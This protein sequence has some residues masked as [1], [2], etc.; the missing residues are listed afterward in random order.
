MTLSDLSGQL[1]G[2]SVVSVVFNLRNLNVNLPPHS[3]VKVL[4]QECVYIWV[5]LTFSPNNK[6]LGFSLLLF[7]L[8]I[9]RFFH[10]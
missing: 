6:F 5:R 9:D 7:K 4:Y 1:W 3:C 10:L 8:K 2:K